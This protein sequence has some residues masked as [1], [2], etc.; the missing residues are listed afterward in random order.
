MKPYAMARSQVFDAAAITPMGTIPE[1]LPLGEGDAS[2]TQQAT[3][4]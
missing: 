1:R 3:S 4:H 2:V